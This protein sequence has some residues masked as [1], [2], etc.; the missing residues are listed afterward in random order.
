MTCC[1]FDEEENKSINF[2]KTA[3]VNVDCLLCRQK[4]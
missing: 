1:F 2:F 4:D 3:D